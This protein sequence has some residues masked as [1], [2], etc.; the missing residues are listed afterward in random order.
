MRKKGE[1][2]QRDT[3]REGGNREREREESGWEDGPKERQEI[4]I[5]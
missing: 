3:G 1:E 5:N 2:G 4:H